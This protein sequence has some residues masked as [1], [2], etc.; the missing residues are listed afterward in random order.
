MGG[1]IPCVETRFPPAPATPHENSA[2]RLPRSNTHLELTLP[3]IYF[4]DLI[5]VKEAL[6]EARD[7]KY[8]L[9]VAGSEISVL[10]VSFLTN[11]RILSPNR[12]YSLSSSLQAKRW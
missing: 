10:T 8:H 2:Y 6:F 12:S 5:Q 3:T 11:L 1:S 9:S 4:F 7:Q